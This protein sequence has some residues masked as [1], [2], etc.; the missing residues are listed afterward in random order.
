MSGNGQVVE[1][2]PATGNG[3]LPPGPRA[4]MAAQM[5]RWIFRPA[6][7]LE[8]CA[9]R[10]GEYFT[11]NLPPNGK[12]VFLT[13]PEGVKTVFRGDPKSFYAGEGNRILEPMLGPG[14][15]LLLDEGDHMRTRKLLLPPFHGERMR[16]YTDIMTAVTERH[17]DRWPVGRP[18]ALH[19]QMQAVTL[20]V[21]IRT[22]FGIEDA[23]RVEHVRQVLTRALGT[24]PVIL[25]KAFQKDLGPWSPW[26]RYKRSKAAVDEFIFEEV[27]N[28]RATAEGRDDVM[29]LLLQAH[30][31]EGEKMGSSELR[32]ELMT[33]LT[34]GHETTA[35]ALAWTF[36]RVLRHPEV[37]ERL[38]E[39]AV[40]G[41]D[42]RYLD[43]V[44]QETLRLRP[45]L[46]IVVR[47]LKA[48]KRIGPWDL[49]AETS[50]SPCIYLMHLRPDLYPD[51][52]AFRP[53]RFLENP[54]ETY[55]WIPFG[56]GVRRCLGIAFA[57]AEMRVVIRTMLKRLDLRAADPE[58]EP[59]RRRNITFC[60]RDGGRVVI[61]G[62]RESRPR[63]PVGV[64]AT[65]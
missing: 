8:A 35:T 20:E 64:P 32:D 57:Q 12:M 30:D 65:A 17:L 55:T 63:Q 26:G 3:S 23:D 39:E 1:R 33:L 24:P 54:P 2:E 46:P 22:V 49:P 5:T 43:A 52:Y 31:E 53:E 47:T 15:I 6:E 59:I 7:M 38:R 11:L 37:L 14:S 21:I 9:E 18:F 50:V 28:R 27:A 29:S 13:D 36:E 61:E 51:P 56:G 62:R 58:P 16:H 34:S 25:V 19:P 44:I 41:G 45:I 60:P 48:P 40:E 10:Y 42:D 4:P